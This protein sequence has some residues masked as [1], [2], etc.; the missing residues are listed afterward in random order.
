[1]SEETRQEGMDDLFETENQPWMVLN[2]DGID[3]PVAE[4]KEVKVQQGSVETDARIYYPEGEGPFPVVFYI[5]GGAFVGGFNAMDEPIC[6]MICHEAGCA[7]ISPNYQLAP[8]HKFPEGLN[9][10]YGLLLYFKANADEYR[11]DMSRIAV[12]GA[13]AG[14]NYAA[15][16]CVKAYQEKDLSFK[17]QI[18]LYPTLDMKSAPEDKVTPF[19][20]TQAMP[21]EGVTEMVQVYLQQD[22]DPGDPLVSPFFAPEEAFPKT[23]VF[24]PRKCIFWKEGRDFAC[25]LMDA[26]VEV[27]LK[28]Y[29]NVG[30][31]FM[32]LRGNE[33]VSRDVKNLVCSE[34]KRNL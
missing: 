26:G 7:V 22:Q 10:L 24:I 34:L 32:E 9:E 33:H 6:R 20:D 16:L 31:G 21:P 30:H 18:L 8:D 2:L 23:G 1:M 14:A 13:S 17:Y 11:M 5:H 3:V 12:G 19:T 4:V 27:L 29:E 25:K 15:A 28:S